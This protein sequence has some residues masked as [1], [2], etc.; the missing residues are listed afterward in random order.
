MQLLV[1]QLIRLINLVTLISENAFIFSW[2]QK[3]DF[4]IHSKF[5]KEEFNYMNLIQKARKY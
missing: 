2:S 1:Y 4:N 3:L 5:Y